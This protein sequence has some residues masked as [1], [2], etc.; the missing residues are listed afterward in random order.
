MNCIMK[1]IILSFLLHHANR[2]VFLLDDRNLFYEIKDNLLKK[3]GSFVRYD[4]Q[5]IEGKKCRSCGG[6]G[7]HVKYSYN[8]PYKAY[9]WS[10]C[11]HCVGGWFKFPQWN[12]LSVISF[13]LYCFHSPTK[14][15]YRIN[16]PWTEEKMGWDFS[17]SPVIKG[18]IEHAESKFGR[19]SML[20]LFRL[21]NN[22][23]Y[24]I[25]LAES[26]KSLKWVFKRR[27]NGIKK[28]SVSDLI[29]NKPKWPPIH[30]ISADGNFE[31][32]PF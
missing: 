22:A 9:D 2:S 14:R 24:K 3:Y 20:I 18:Y 28:L 11:W 7:Q 12:L 17:K 26:I 29:L 27:I 25:L 13:G 19:I 31:E 32:L 6:S 23:Q 30:W 21:Y 4:V 5:H 8:S 1:K 16:N 10:D 15:E